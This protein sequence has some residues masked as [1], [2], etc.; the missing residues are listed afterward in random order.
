MSTGPLRRARCIPVILRAEVKRLL[1]LGSIAVSL[2]AAGTTSSARPPALLT[3]SRASEPTGLCI[4]RADGSRRFR[5]TRG[6][7][8]SPSWSPKGYYVAFARQIDA[9]RS[10][11]LVADARGKI[12]RRFGTGL[13]TEPAWSPNG[14]RI[15]YASDGRVIVATTAGRTMADGFASDTGRWA[16]LVAG[17]TPRRVRGG[18]G[19][20]TGRRTR[21]LRR[22]RGRN[23]PPAARQRRSRSGLVAR[24]LQA[25]LRRLRV[26]AH[27]QTGSSPLRTPTAPAPA[28]SRRRATPSRSRRGHRADGSSRS[29]AEAR[30]SS[31]RAQEARSG[32]RFETRATPPGGRRR[33][34]RVGVAAPAKASD[35]HSSLLSYRPGAP[36]PQRPGVEHGEW[37]VTSTAR[38]FPCANKRNFTQAVLFV[39]VVSRKIPSGFAVLTR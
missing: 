21:D 28:G 12:L 11:I 26:P 31:R 16:G 7:D 17:L 9:S 20:G 1:L 15:A 5:L 24:R 18:P 33:R 4:A 39:L 3:Y 36:T 38:P 25:R 27:R 13:S 10:Q 29:R 19:G 14:Q 6:K 32:S 22:Q 30:S 2:A 23:G 34:C 35:A 8:G 37:A